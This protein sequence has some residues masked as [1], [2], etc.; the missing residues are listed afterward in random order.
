MSPVQKISSPSFDFQDGGKKALN[1]E[2]NVEVARSCTQKNTFR[3]VIKPKSMN[4][5][6]VGPQLFFVRPKR[7]EG[8]EAE[9]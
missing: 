3:A 9:Q 7:I 8:K 5:G 1:V 4:I 2:F 6:Y